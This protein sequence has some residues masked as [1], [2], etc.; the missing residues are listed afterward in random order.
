MTVCNKKR[1]YENAEKKMRSLFNSQH[2]NETKASDMATTHMTK[3]NNCFDS[4]RS[5]FW[6]FQSSI[7]KDKTCNMSLCV[8]LELVCARQLLK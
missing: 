3:N 8:S 6:N 5:V 4:A 7:F 2:R 1:E